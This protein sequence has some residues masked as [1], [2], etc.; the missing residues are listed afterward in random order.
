MSE[1]QKALLVIGCGA[2][3]AVYAIG[4]WQQRLHRRKFGAVFKKD[5]EDALYHG[6][7]DK[8]PEPIQKF[9]LSDLGGADLLP[10]ADAPVVVADESCT[11]LSAR[12]DFIVELRLLEPSPASVLGSL[13]QRK[14]DFGKAVQVCGMTLTTRQ[15]ERAAAESQTLYSHFRIAL[16]LVDRNGLISSA[17]LADFRDLVIGFAQHIKA[18]S[19]VPDVQETMHAALQL[20]AFCVVVDQMVGINLMPAGDRLLQGVKI[21]QAAAA[22]GMTLEPDGAFHLLNARGHSQ[23]SLINRDTKVFQH[24]TL[25]R[26]TTAGLTLLLDVPRVENPAEQFDRMLLVA[27]ELAKELQVNLVDDRRIELS[28]GGLMRIRTKVSEVEAKMIEQDI[29]PGSAQARRLFS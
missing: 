21:A 2:I 17:K 4:W 8:S 16:Q 10:V 26:F 1:L 28:E 19:T 20:D 23:F 6:T 25:E 29:V 15:W 12:S 24:H 3:I 18:K 7:Y 14:F 9:K 5:R 27:H 13:W 11:V 22:Q